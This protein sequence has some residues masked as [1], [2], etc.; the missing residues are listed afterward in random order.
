MLSNNTKTTII[1]LFAI[2]LLCSCGATSKCPAYQSR[3]SE[4][5]DRG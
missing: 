2:F 5:V 1:L 4:I 3:T